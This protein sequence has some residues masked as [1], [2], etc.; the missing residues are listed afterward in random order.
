MGIYG[1]QLA[2]LSYCIG[3][4]YKEACR[5]FEHRCIDDADLTNKGIGNRIEE[6]KNVDKNIDS[7]RR[8][9]FSLLGNLYSYKCKVSPTVLFHVWSIFVSPVLRS[10]LAALPIRPPVIKSAIAF[11][12]KILRGI[13]KF[14]SPVC[15]SSEY[16]S[17]LKCSW[18]L[19]EGSI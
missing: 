13:L 17:N 5:S 2:L 12:R 7:A 8:S 14:I 3:K 16:F 18:L 6:Q 15:V 10:G 11:H 1:V 19:I 9:L 4:T